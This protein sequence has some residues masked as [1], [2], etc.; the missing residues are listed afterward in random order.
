MKRL[1]FIIAIFIIC[2]ASHLFA[3]EIT[4]PGFIKTHKA[5]IRLGD[6]AQLKGCNDHWKDILLAHIVRPGATIELPAGY[7]KARLKLKG[8]P[9]ERL[10]LNIP[11]VVKIERKAI[12]ITKRDLI[13]MTRHCI[14]SN[15]PWGNRL[16]ITQI[17]PQNDIMLPQGKLSYSCQLENSPLGSFSLPIIFK[18][19]GHIAARTWVMVKTSLITP[20]VVSAYPIQRGEIITK[21]KLRIIK[22]DLSGLPAGIFFNKNALIGKRAKV[23]IGANRIIYKNM[24]EIPPVIKR[25]QRVMIIAESDSLKVTV[26]GKAKENGR[27]GDI[28]KVQNLLSK[29]VVVGKVVSDQT[30]RVKF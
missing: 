20:I 1:T 10:K 5:E 27:I 29:K 13:A 22:K 18:V 30:V 26:P 17:R 6:I 25:G 28:I 16:R 7:I 9:V 23:N 24:V 4:I 2:V 11:E 12:K 21:D 3:G 8:V 14:K 15:N 19:N